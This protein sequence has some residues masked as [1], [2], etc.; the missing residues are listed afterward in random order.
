MDEKEK[1]M[2][3]GK[4]EGEEI[5]KKINCASIR[6]KWESKMIFDLWKLLEKKGKR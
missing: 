5:L 3:K 4:R 1:E 6:N 2:N